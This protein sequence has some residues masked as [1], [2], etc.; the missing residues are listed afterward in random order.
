MFVVVVVVYDNVE[1]VGKYIM[2]VISFVVVVVNII[3]AITI[4]VSTNPLCIIK[5][6]TLI[7]VI[8]NLHD[9]SI[10]VIA[11]YIVVEIIIMMTII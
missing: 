9:A 2:V 1:E 11:L 6:N 10:I 7:F 4:I 3:V 5:L 8:A